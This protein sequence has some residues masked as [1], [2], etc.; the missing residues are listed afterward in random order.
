M[1]CASKP[2]ER[3]FFFPGRES[4]RTKYGVIDMQW[5]SAVPFTTSVSPFQ[6]E[7]LPQ[8]PDHQ[9]SYDNRYEVG[10]TRRDRCSLFRKMRGAQM[11]DLNCRSVMMS[12][13]N[14]DGERKSNVRCLSVSALSPCRCEYHQLEFILAE[15][16]RPVT[17]QRLVVRITHRPTRPSPAPGPLGA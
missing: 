6:D 8:L 13:E 9:H 5:T 1:P 16:T 12:S 17:C 7:R 3:W 4:G 10:Q 15:S 2:T 14:V 11:Q